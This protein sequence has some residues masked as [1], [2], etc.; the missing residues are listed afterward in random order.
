MTM[1]EMW[2]EVTEMRAILESREGSRVELAAI[3]AELSDLQAGLE[4]LEM[5]Q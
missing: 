2:G 4:A 1:D 5:A 3:T